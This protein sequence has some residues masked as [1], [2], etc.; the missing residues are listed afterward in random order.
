MNKGDFMV[1]IIEMKQKEVINISDGCRLGYVSDI[2]ICVKEGKLKK[3]IIPG[4]GKIMG[5]FGREQEYQVDWEK[6][7]KIGDDI[8]LVDVNID[9]ILVDSE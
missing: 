3:I 8:I 9:K 2:M 5:V 4:P 6:I 1:R 7:K